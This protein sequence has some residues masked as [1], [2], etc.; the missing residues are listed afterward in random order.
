MGARQG[1]GRAG[2]EETDVITLFMIGGIAGWGR[3]SSVALSTNNSRSQQDVFVCRRAVAGMGGSKG[4]LRGE[5]VTRTQPNQ[6]SRWI[7][8]SHLLTNSPPAPPPR[9]L[10]G[11][12]HQPAPEMLASKL[13][14][15]SF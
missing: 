12:T 5:E 15:L 3:D 8:L 13:I 14:F 9:L 4:W 6:T 10:I 1:Q 2:P 7:S 11:L